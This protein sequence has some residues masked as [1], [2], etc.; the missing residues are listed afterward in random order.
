[1]YFQEISRHIVRLGAGLLAGLLSFSV[2]V[3]L[4]SEEIK[5][6]EKEMLKYF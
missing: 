3:F 5:M 2:E 4:H 6:V 1:M